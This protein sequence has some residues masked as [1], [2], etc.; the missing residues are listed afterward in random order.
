M[1]HRRRFG[2]HFRKPSARAAHSSI[3]LVCGMMLFWT[4]S[5]GMV[6]FIVPLKISNA[7]FSD[8]MLGFIIGTSS[9]AGALFDLV[10]CRVFKNTF[11]KRIFGLMFVLCLSFPLLLMHATT[12][13]AFVIGMA[14]W[15]IYYDLRNIGNFDYIAR[16]TDKEGSAQAFGLIQVFQSVGWIIGPIL[17]GFLAGEVVGWKPFAA[18]YTFLGISVA[19]FIMLYFWKGT[20][21]RQKDPS[22]ERPCRRGTWSEGKMIGLVAYALF[23]ALFS[24]FFINF[25]DSFFWSIGPLFAEELGLGM[26]AGLFITAWSL[27]AMLLGWNAGK[28]ALK[29]GKER[30]AYGAQL[31]AVLALSPI[32]LVHSGIAI[33]VLIFIAASF[34]ALAVPAYQSMFTDYIH[35]R[36]DLE[37]EIESLEDLYTNLGYVFGPILAGLSSD[38]L[39]YSLTFSLLG[40]GVALMA[41]FL[42]MANKRKKGTFS[43]IAPPLI[44]DVT[45]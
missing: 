43:Q 11:Y 35:E 42:F 27:P 26:F 36:E 1:I 40:S 23:P 15:G 14:I 16:T 25:V 4:L 12:L 38:L 28:V 22:K 6:S 31:L 10:A 29:F 39:G 13:L 18:I 5:E 17:V 2:A 20:N 21:K 44:C 45:D 8:T 30:V 9:L 19:F 37:K 32:F 24:I 34:T 33:I 7:G 3:F 41:V